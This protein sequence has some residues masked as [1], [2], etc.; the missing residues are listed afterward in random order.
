[1]GE[2]ARNNLLL[3]IGILKTALLDP[4][5]RLLPFKDQETL[6]HWI[7]QNYVAEGPKLKNK[8]LAA[9]TLKNSGKTL[10]P[11]FASTE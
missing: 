4:K 3:V 7:E 2:T 5:L 9:D 11:S 1:M 10:I 8:G 6:R